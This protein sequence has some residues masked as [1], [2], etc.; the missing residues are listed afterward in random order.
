MTSCSEYM[1]GRDGNVV[2][3]HPARAAATV[4]RPAR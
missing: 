4:P 1:M 2:A 3:G